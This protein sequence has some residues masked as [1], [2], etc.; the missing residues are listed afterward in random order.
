ML[1]ETKRAEVENFLRTIG[2]WLAKHPDELEI[3][4]L[5]GTHHT[6]I[7]IQP[8]VDDVGSFIGNR[9]VTIRSIQQLTTAYSYKLRHKLIVEIISPEQRSGPK[10]RRDHG[11]LPNDNRSDRPRRPFNGQDP[12]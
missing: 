5:E 11:V 9:G 7:E 10:R 2:R 3:R 12:T 6:I 1:D 8:H 4:F